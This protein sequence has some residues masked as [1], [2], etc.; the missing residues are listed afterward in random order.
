L[1]AFAI[2]ETFHPDSQAS[3]NAATGTC[4]TGSEA[5]SVSTTSQATFSK[6][7]STVN[8]TSVSFTQ[9]SSGCVEV[10]FSSEALTSPN[11]I[12]LTQAMLDGNKVCIPGDNLFAA[13]S[14]GFPSTHTMNYICPS[15]SAGKHTV[16]IQFASRY[17]SRV[18]V[19][20]HT[21]I[22]RY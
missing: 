6:S 15:V 9:G 2:S 12:L 5:Y 11:E 17:G 1:P 20:Y 7:F 18:Q 19:Y 16:T 21:A 13:P 10:S 4:E 14:S 3:S 8:G 22:V